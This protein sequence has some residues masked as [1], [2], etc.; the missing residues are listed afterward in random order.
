MLFIE[1]GGFTGF[2]A[3]YLIQTVDTK[4]QLGLSTSGSSWALELPSPLS[5]NDNVWHHI[6]ATRSGETARLFIDGVLVAT[7]TISGS[8]MAISS[9]IRIGRNTAGST[10]FQFAGNM[11]DFMVTK[12]VARYTTNFTPPSR[13]AKYSL[14]RINTGADSH[15]YDRAILHNWRNDNGRLCIAAYPDSDGNFSVQDLVDIEYGTAFIKEGCLPTVVGPCSFD[16][17]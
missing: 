13:R 15:E 10:T 9:A 7:G 16:E 6:A 1:R 3:F 11:Q 4:I 2:T 17:D 8:L 5:Y 12:G 14:T